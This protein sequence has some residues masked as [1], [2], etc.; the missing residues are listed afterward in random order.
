MPMLPGA[1]GSLGSVATRQLVADGTIQENRTAQLS[2]YHTLTAI[3]S[4]VTPLV[5]GYLV[6]TFGTGEGFRLGILIA[7]ATSPIPIILLVKYLRQS[8]QGT[9]AKR[10]EE[11]CW[12][13]IAIKSS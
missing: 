5:G 9:T 8:N 3:P 2:L 4:I 6:H 7:L 13:N 10:K 11:L 1:A 12:P